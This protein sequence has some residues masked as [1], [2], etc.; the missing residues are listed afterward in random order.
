MVLN[1]KTLVVFDIEV[2]KNFFCCSFRN[3]ETKEINTFEI[4]SFQPECSVFYQYFFEK[5]LKFN[6]KLQ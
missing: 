2:F 6:N 3:T 1:D 4:W 5:H